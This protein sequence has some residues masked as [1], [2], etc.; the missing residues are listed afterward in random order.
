VFQLRLL[1]VFWALTA[2]V[3]AGC[4][5]NDMQP[6]RR[7]PDLVAFDQIVVPAKFETTPL[8]ATSIS[9]AIQPCLP[10]L[11]SDSRP[12]LPKLVREIEESKN[13]VIVYAHPN[14]GNL[15]VMTRELGF[16]VQRS[17]ALLPVLAAETLLDTAHPIGMPAAVHEDWNK[18]IARRLATVGQLKVAYKLANGDA[19]LVQY[20]MDSDGSRI[21]VRYLH[22]LKQAGEWEK[23]LLDLQFSHPQA[24]GFLVVS[25]TNTPRAGAQVKTSPID[26]RFSPPMPSRNLL[27]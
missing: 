10:W 12:G 27:R 21:R 19:N 7:A 20:W 16:C 13:T 25:T 6:S 1:R 2:C 5:A 17:T 24:N 9:R 3:L 18:Q 15:F 14:S 26:H 23:E 8:T 4:A 22:A 11:L